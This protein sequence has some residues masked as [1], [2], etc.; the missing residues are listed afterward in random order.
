MTPIGKGGVY[1]SDPQRAGW[2][3]LASQIVVASGVGPWF[4]VQDVDAILAKLTVG[5]LGVNEVQKAIVKATGGSFKLT[6][7]GQTTA[8][9][10]WN[11]SAA[12][13]LAALLALSNLDTGDVTVTGGPGDEGGTTPYIFTFR[14]GAN[15][16]EMTADATALTGGEHKVEMSTTTAG[17]AAGSLKVALETKVQEDAYIVAEFPEVTAADPSVG[18]AFGPLGTEC[19]W[20]WTLGATQGAKFSV[21]AS[22]R[23]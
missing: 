22:D 15:I 13:V 16:A 3:D 5:R 4:D 19:R 7:T 2:A 1:Y 12:E 20:K 21:S 23:V 11:A 6:Y 8:A 9:I 17:T 10:K 14:E 18:K